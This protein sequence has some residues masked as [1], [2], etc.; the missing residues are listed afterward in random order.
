[1]NSD[2]SLVIPTY[3]MSNYLVELFDSIN[4]S[5]LVD[6]VD[7]IILVNDG[8]TDDTLIQLQQYVSLNNKIKILNLKSNKGRFLAR[9]YGA[10]EAKCN[11]ILFL[12]SRNKLQDKF[13]ENLQKVSKLYDNVIGSVDIDISKNSFCL[14]W[15]RSHKF[16][17][18]KHYEAAK[19]II[20]LS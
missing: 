14:Y 7:E 16:I 11:R 10:K 3:N 2:V 4:N 19:Q 15:D 1:M 17:F 13:V 8:S 18:K 6:F 5:G 20:K 9:Y 12:D